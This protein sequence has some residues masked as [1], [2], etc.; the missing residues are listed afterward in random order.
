[1]GSDAV[2]TE[3]PGTCAPRVKG[4][5]NS[6][7]TR[8]PAVDGK[9]SRCVFTNLAFKLSVPISWLF[10]IYNFLYSSL[11]IEV[12]KDDVFMKRGKV[13]STKRS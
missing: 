12:A 9:N 2:E 13:F 8:Q 1:M 7:L 4:C 5:S 10:M 11:L 6:R 3:L